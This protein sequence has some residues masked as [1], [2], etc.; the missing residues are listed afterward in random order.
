MANRSSA[1]PPRA[2]R[3]VLCCSAAAAAAW[4]VGE[5]RAGGLRPRGGAGR[6]RRGGGARAAT[7][8]FGVVELERGRWTSLD[9]RLLY[10]IGLVSMGHAEPAPRSRSGRRRGR[11]SAGSPVWR[12]QPVLAVRLGGRHQQTCFFAAGAETA[13]LVRLPGARSIPRR[14]AGRGRPRPRCTIGFGPLPRGPAPA[15]G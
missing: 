15:T 1:T 8:T 9:A 12:P 2:T 7:R 6:M 10:V 5:T 11:R 4:L 3:C 13:W 14:A